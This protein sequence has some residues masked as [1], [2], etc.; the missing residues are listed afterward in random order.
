MV[1]TIR[2]SGF[3]IKSKICAGLAAINWVVCI[4]KWGYRAGDEQPGYGAGRS[5]VG[6]MQAYIERGI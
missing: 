1:V 2:P 6:K 5:A 4:H 3:K